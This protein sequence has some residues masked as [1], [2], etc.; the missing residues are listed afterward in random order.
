MTFPRKRP[1][2]PSAKRKS[3]TDA[4]PGGH[5]PSPQEKPRSMIDRLMDEGMTEEQAGR[6]ISDTLM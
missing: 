5:Q 2:T 1:S 4:Q 6:I 3:A